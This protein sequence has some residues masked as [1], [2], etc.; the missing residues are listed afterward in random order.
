MNPLIHYIGDSATYGWLLS[1]PANAPADFE[2][3]QFQVLVLVDDGPDIEIPARL[4][5]GEVQVGGTPVEDPAIMA[6]DLGPD[7][8]QLAPATYRALRRLNAGDGWQV[9]PASEFYLK[10]RS[11]DQ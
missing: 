7:D 2:G 6:I 8:L 10:L 11:F 9:I 3:L 4:A 1:A 5:G